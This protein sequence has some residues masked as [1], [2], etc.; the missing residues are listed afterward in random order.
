M[1][2]LSA[3]LILSLASVVTLAS[4][5]AAAPGATAVIVGRVIDAQSGQTL[6]GVMVQLGGATAASGPARQ[7]RAV[8]DGQGRFIFSGLT[9]GTYLVMALAGGNGYS[10]NGFV[11]TGMGFPI[12]AYLEGG[13]GQRRPG[14]PLRPIELTEGQRIIDADIRMWRSA[15]VSGR[16]VDEA[17]EPAVDQVVGVVQVNSEGRL[18]NGPTMRTDDRGA[19]RFSGLTPGAYV[20]FVPQTVVSMP[21][22]IADE[23]AAGPPDPI[24]GRRFNMTSAPS[25]ANGGVRV[26]DSLVALTSDPARFPAG[27]T[28]TNSRAPVAREGRLYVYPTTFHP[29]AAGLAQGAR[30][31]LSPGEQREN[32]DIH[33]Q[34]VPAGSVAGTVVDDAG[35]VAGMGL[36][37]LPADQ[38]DDASIL[39]AAHTATDSRGAF[40]FPVVP[41]GRYTIVAWRVG[42][43]PTGNQ[44]QP[45]A[46]PTRVSEQSGAWAMQAVAVGP[47]P[48]NNV[49]V[50]LRPP[51]TVN[52]RIEFSG[53]SPRPPAERLRTGFLTTIARANTMFRS[54]GPSSGS[55]MDPA[56]GRISVKGV[57]PP[58]R[59]FAG[60]PSIPAPWS[61]ESITLA[62]QDVTDAAFTVG[63]SDINDLV[64][65]Y[66]D[67]PASITGT[68][69]GAADEA[70]VFV[71][72]VNRTRWPDARVSSRT[73]RMTRPSTIGSFNLT[74]MPPGDYFAI[75]IRDEDAADWPDPQFLTR[76]ASVASVVK[77][78]ANQPTNL[79]LKVSVLK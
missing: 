19:Y 50:T 25:P 31:R 17:G 30:I 42:G 78:L 54:P 2:R 18:L 9:K 15:V 79:P 6:A 44:Q 48:V 68:I 22:S 37:L 75:A 73:F 3:W 45:F 10:A 49:K 77:V 23:L 32:V 39:E 51:V 56:T 64:I 58:G 57:S 27:T 36:R 29:A 5:Q 69:S 71:F 21:S 28:F 61:V 43:V 55:L 52:G 4:Q 26:G 70:T 40:V 46:A 72:P 53:S 20:A 38:G 13:F 35:A 65:T 59:F 34:P 63:E 14:G 67:R 12:G 11:V 66:T 60:P 76:L 33:L 16:V 74:N 1:R 24:A 8:T 47:Q 7:T 41:A 62:G